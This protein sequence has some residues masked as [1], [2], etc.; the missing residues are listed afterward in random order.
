MKSS[1]HAA[2]ISWSGH[3]D[4]AHS[5]SSALE[6]CVDKLT[7]IYSNKAGEQE[8]GPGN[9]IQV[10]DR[11]FF[12]LKFKEALFAHKD[13]DFFLLIQA[14]ASHD[15]WPE[16]V[17]AL[18]ISAHMRPRL[19]VWAPDIDWSYWTETKALLA[20]I[21]DSRLH[22]TTQ[23]DAIV[24]AYSKNVVR[25]M[26]E[27]DYSVNNLGWGIDTFANCFATSSGADVLRDSS[28]CI[29]HEKGSGYNHEAAIEQMQKFLEQ[30]N[31]RENSTK[32]LFDSY[33]YLE[34]K[35]GKIS[36]LKRIWKRYVK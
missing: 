12:G 7:V 30:M 15:S 19:G 3:H 36:G 26:Q 21:P 18:R 2:I 9:W 10:D 25:R 33:C 23:T 5:I 16:V 13:E 27:L 29:K 32:L 11:F 17:N 35:K 14:D 34:N 6:S 31:D 1:V 22:H 20:P 24:C 4:Q 28:I 8:A